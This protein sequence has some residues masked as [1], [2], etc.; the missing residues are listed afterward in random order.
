[1]SGQLEIASLS[2][3]RRL[4]LLASWVLAILGTLQ[5]HR[6]SLLEACSICGPWGCGPPASALVGYHVFWSLL[7]FPAAWILKSRWC[8]VTARHLGT[9]LMALSLAGTVALLLYEG[10]DNSAA[11]NYPLRWCLFRV[12]TF[13][14]FPLVQ[15][16]LAGLWLRM[17]KS[18]HATCGDPAEEQES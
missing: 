18:S 17:T 11:E 7:V 16:G 3:T 1:M 13:V 12:A 6:T 14:D 10:L 2:T 5:I 9:G 8:A 15:L 4:I